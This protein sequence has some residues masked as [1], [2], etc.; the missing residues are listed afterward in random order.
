MNIADYV[1]IIELSIKIILAL[2]SGSL[3]VWTR[4][5]THLIIWMWGETILNC[6][7]SLQMQMSCVVLCLQREKRYNPFDMAKPV[8]EQRFYFNQ[9]PSVILPRQRL[10]FPF[11]FKSDLA[12]IFS[13]HWQ[14]NTTPK[15]CGG[16]KL[17]VS[18]R[19]IALKVDKYLPVRQHINVSIAMLPP[20]LPLSL[21]LFYSIPGR[22]V[23]L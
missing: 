6:A 8:L 18:L 4:S 1:I 20:L 14:L 7:P 12:G 19:G 15:L 5:E 3:F 17:V 11:V 22:G 10:L 2:L 9:G 21:S 13:E 16:A 23:A